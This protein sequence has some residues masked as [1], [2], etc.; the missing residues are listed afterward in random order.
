MSFDRL[1][2]LITGG[3]GFIGSNLAIKLDSLGADITIVDSM[4]PDYGGNLFNI[5]PVK[6]KLR[7]NFSDMRDIHTLPYLVGSNDVIFN[8]AGQ[9]SH[10]DSMKAPSTDLDINVRAQISLLEACRKHNPDAVIVYTSTRQIY[11]KPQYLP[12]DEAHPLC[13][14]DVNGI[15]KLAGE[16][17]HLLYHKVYGIKTVALRLTNTYGP[18]Q[19]IKNSRQGFIGWFIKKVICDE[20]IE[21]F[22]DGSQVRDLT[23]VDDVVDALI[24][25]AQ[26][27]ECF[28]NVYNLGGERISL[29]NL[30]NLMISIA[31]KGWYELIP[32]PEER[33]KIDIGDFYGD[34][35]K[36][37]KV[38]EW[39]PKV[40]LC[41]GLQRTIRYYDE[42]KRKYLD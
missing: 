8:L 10:L 28:G 40:S 23:F 17:Y 5:E 3:I 29:K 42:N 14:V 26:T 38:T 2:C 11:G 16:Q 18:R 15:N 9:V 36:F 30:V 4:I 27:P 37:R 6:D 19:L 7:V 24:I 34:Y 1:K 39:E 22:G 32:F 13:P 31:G 35:T 21:I 41:D 25:A 12:V 20:K 33:K